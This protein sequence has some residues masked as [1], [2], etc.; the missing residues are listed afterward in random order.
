MSSARK[1]LPEEVRSGPFGIRVLG[2]CTICGATFKQPPA[3]R[4]RI[5]CRKAACARSR[6][7]QR[8]ANRPLRAKYTDA[9]RAEAVTAWHGYCAACAEPLARDEEGKPVAHFVEDIIPVHYGCVKK[10]LPA[11]T[12]G[13][14]GRCAA[15]CPL[16]KPFVGGVG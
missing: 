1:Y 12:W 3:G 16:P 15:G 11:R 9:D 14:L 4:P 5:L 10:E 8:E 2:T 7:G 6:R 13:W